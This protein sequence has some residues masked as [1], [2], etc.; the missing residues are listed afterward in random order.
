MVSDCRDVD[1]VRSARGSRAVG[2]GVRSL[3]PR[4]QEPRWSPVLPRLDLP[5]DL[6]EW[7]GSARSSSPARVTAAANCRPTS[8]RRSARCTCAGTTPPLARHRGGGG[9]GRRRCSGGPP[10]ARCGAAGRRDRRHTGAGC[11]PCPHSSSRPVTRRYGRPAWSGWRSRR[12]PHNRPARSGGPR[13]GQGPHPVSGHPGHR[14]HLCPSHSEPRRRIS[15]RSRLTGPAWR[16]MGH[17]SATAPPPLSAGAA[18]CP[19]AARTAH[20]SAGTPAPV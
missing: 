14:P 12:R 7:V 2:E 3:N 13:R 19:P 11:S 10:R 9:S 4:A 17:R 18:G 8:V 5:H 15:R 6:A 16:P 20:R 1:E